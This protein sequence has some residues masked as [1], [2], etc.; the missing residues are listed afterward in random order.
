MRKKICRPRAS[1][2]YFASVES[3]LLCFSCPL[4]LVCILVCLHFNLVRLVLVTFQIGYLRWC[5]M[6]IELEPFFWNRTGR[7]NDN[8]ARGHEMALC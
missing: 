1:L 7:R 2:R 3:P 5:E 8:S 4:V 6:L